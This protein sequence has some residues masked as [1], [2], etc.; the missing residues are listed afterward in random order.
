MTTDQPA[1][2]ARDHPLLPRARRG[3]AERGDDRHRGDHPLRLR[4]RRRAAGRRRAARGPRPA[5]RPDPAQAAEE[6]LGAARRGRPRAGRV[7]RRSSPPA[8]ASGP[9]PRPARAG[10]SPS[11]RPT[12]WSATPTGS[13]PWSRS[14][15]GWCRTSR[16]CPTCVQPAAAWSTS[17]PAASADGPEAVA[18]S[19]P[20]VHL[21]VASGYS[22]QLRRLPPA[23]R[24]SSGPPSR[25]WTPSRSPTATAPTAR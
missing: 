24:W 9:R 4:P 18:M 3:V 17:P 7:G 15:S 20:F 11:A 23:R 1:R 10:R 19:D 12:T 14:R 6:R 5:G 16:R 25:R 2:A 21:H 22:L 8:P 13:W